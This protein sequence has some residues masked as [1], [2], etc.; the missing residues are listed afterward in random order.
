MALGARKAS[1]IHADDA[2]GRAIK[3]DFAPFEGFNFK[4]N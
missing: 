4:E 1:V 3:A 2:L